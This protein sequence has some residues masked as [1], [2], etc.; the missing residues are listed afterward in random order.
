MHICDLLERVQLTTVHTTKD[1]LLSLLLETLTCKTP[2][3]RTCV[4]NPSLNDVGTLTGFRQTHCCETLS[5]T[6]HHV[7]KM[8]F[9]NNSLC[10][11]VLGLGMEEVS[12]L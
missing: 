3:I 8:L 7:Q 5:L 6:A 12:W 2:S 10:G 4:L 11:K 1:N 9:W